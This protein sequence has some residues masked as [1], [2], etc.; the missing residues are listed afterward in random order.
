MQLLARVYSSVQTGKLNMSESSLSNQLQ[1]AIQDIKQGNLKAGKIALTQ[2]INTEPNSPYAEKAWLWMSATFSDAEQKRM[3]LENALKINPDN[4]TAQKGLEKLPPPPAVPDE[5]E[6]EDPEWLVA[7]AVA[8]ETV[9]TIPTTQNSQPQL[10]QSQKKPQPPRKS[11]QQIID[12]YIALQ[13]ARGWQVVSHTSTS[14]QLRKPKQWSSLLLVIGFVLLCL[15]GTG[16]IVLLLALVDYLS[17]KDEVEF[18]TA[19]ELRNGLVKHRIGSNQSPIVTIVV[20]LGLIFIGLTVI[21]FLYLVVS[22]G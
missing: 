15:Y 11:D 21:L 20:M 12:E 10:S 18:V 13:T 17:K 1:A 14:V 4:V 6:F 22:N 7:D 8:R 5:E 2:V 19:E 9:N 3:C 16:L